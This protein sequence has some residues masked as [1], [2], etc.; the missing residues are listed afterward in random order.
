M[1][2]LLFGL[3]ALSSVVAFAGG[4]GEVIP[5]P[6]AV[7]EE[8]TFPGWQF[9]LFG[10]AGAGKFKYDTDYTALDANGDSFLEKDGT[11]V[12]KL[13]FNKDL[14]S[15]SAAWEV[16][17][18]AA[19]NITENFAL[20]IGAAYQ[21]HGDVKSYKNDDWAGEGTFGNYKVQAPT[22]DSAA[23]YGFGKYAFGDYDNLRPYIKGDIGYS[24]NFNEDDLVVDFYDDPTQDKAIY[25]VDIDDGLY[26]G[27]GIGLEYHNWFGQV[28]YKSNQGDL[29]GKI[30]DASIIG[31]DKSTYKGDV[32]F[33]RVVFDLGY[34]FSI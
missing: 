20:G 27:A 4:T 6:V 8:D 17:L 18:E 11:V 9:G 14:D 30:K 32:E 10:G 25:D 2:K 3:F 26:W 19:K 34:R 1:K 22:F 29:D 7:V 24:F 12:D 5:E 15:D 23:V 13:S 28:M 16:G 33:G 31:A 21:D